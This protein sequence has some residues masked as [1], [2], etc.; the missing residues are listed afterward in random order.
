[1]ISPQNM[2][3]ICPYYT[4]YPLEFPLRVLSKSQSE[5][6]WILD[7]FCGRGTTNYA[8]RLLGKPSIGHDSS[9]IAVAIAKAKLTKT[10]VN[11]VL[12][13]T[14]NILENAQFLPKI[15]QGEFWELAFNKKTLLEICIFRET[16][17]KNCSSDAR[18][19][20]R[21]ILLGS[22]HGPVN[23][24]EPSYFSNQCLRTFA[25]KPSYSVDFWK[26]HKLKPKR[27][28]IFNLVKKKA[29]RYLMELPNSVDGNI[30][31]KDSR[32]SDVFNYNQK[33]SWIISSPPY[34]GMRTYIQDQWLRN[35][36]LGGPD[37]IDYNQREADFHHTS[38]D[39]F[40][41]QL[42]SVWI[43]SARAAKSNARFACRF[44]GI[45]NR[46]QDPLMIIKDS[47]K[48]S[49]WRI[50]TI[51]GAGSASDGNRQAKQFGG[52]AKKAP[53]LEYD[54]YATKE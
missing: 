10:T 39:E 36:F 41:T 47:L 43:N 6:E 46:S 19:V 50:N 52:R 49:G 20:L 26:K 35:W 14:T 7:P 24:G 38:V 34:Y 42:R 8:A 23:K 54:V 12:R 21:A 18:I 22:L 51:K 16:L 17:L 25:P 2:N 1:M 4:M 9:E 37:I 45:N 33:F 32:D 40:V 29:E 15:P 3:A 5:M 28:D 30:Y 11:R 53:K 31:V 13:A 27:I 48:D 44:G